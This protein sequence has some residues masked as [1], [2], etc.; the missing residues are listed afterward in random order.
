VNFDF[1]HPLCALGNLYL[2]VLLLRAITSWFPI[3]PDSPIVPL[4]RFLHTVTE[5]VLVPFRK[6]IPPVGMFDL[7]YIVVFFVAEI[8]VNQILCRIG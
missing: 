3:G 6:V 8:F 7:S 1:S 5:P 2:L 4:V